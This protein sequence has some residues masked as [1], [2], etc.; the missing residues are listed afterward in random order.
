MS[1]LASSTSPEPAGNASPS[2]AVVATGG[3]RLGGTPHSRSAASVTGPIA[4]TR[5]PASPAAP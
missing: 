3:T 2:A 5:V 4:A 1:A